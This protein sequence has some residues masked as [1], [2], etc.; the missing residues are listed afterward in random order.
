MMTEQE[1]L[2]LKEEIT[3]AK[4]KFLQLQGQSKALLQQLKED[5]GCK[6]VE[7]AEKKIKEFETEI[8]KLDE[9]IDEG[10]SELEK[11]M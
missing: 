11:L 5:W 3:T 1:L 10:I 6:T 9:E 4:E 8:K 7:Q 2:Q